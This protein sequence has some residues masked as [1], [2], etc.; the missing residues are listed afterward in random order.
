MKAIVLARK[1]YKEF[2]QIITVLTKQEGRKDLISRGVKK[3]ISKNAA[4]L[5]PCCFVSIDITKGKEMNVLLRAVPINIFKEIRSDMHKSYVAQYLA[6]LI[7]K[8]SKQED[9]NVNLFNVLLNSLELLNIS[10]NPFVLLNILLLNIISAIG[11]EPSLDICTICGKQDLENIDL[12][13]IVEKGGVCCKT[14]IKDLE[15]NNYK[16]YT[17]SNDSKKIFKIINKNNLD[18]DKFNK[19]EKNSSKQIEEIHE[20]ILAYTRY[21]L[22]MLIPDWVS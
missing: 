18:F 8:I 11:F 20:I 4:H 1:D 2:D 22:D 21:Y 19:F 15:K 9:V 16:S 7:S 10:K 17:I 13:F 6:I 14:C 5:E 3:I 12:L